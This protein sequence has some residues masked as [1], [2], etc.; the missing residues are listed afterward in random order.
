MILLFMVLIAIEPMYIIWAE[1]RLGKL[2]EYI[3]SN[4]FEC[5]IGIGLFLKKISFSALHITITI[6]RPKIAVI[7]CSIEISNKMNIRNIVFPKADKSL[8]N[9][10][11]TLLTYLLYFI[12]K[13]RRPGF[14]PG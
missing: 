5:F 3:F 2:P 6:K 14:E 4:I 13:M 10:S 1:C 8:I 9:S 12:L 11:S 7:I